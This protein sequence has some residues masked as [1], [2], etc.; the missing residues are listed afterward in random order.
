M[1]SSIISQKAA[2]VSTTMTIF[3]SLLLQ[4]EIFWMKNFVLLGKNMLL[5]KETSAQDRDSPES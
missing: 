4:I 5:L 1:L 2:R 3:Q